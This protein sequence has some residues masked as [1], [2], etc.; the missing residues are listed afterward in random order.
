MVRKFYLTI[1]LKTNF[2]HQVL[3]TFEF[4]HS[5]P[6]LKLNQTITLNRQRKRTKPFLWHLMVISEDGDIDC[7]RFHAKKG[8]KYYIKA[9]ARSVASPLDRPWPLSW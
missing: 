9:H 6:S 7:F 8:D 3:I 1:I 2:S 4:Q 5:R